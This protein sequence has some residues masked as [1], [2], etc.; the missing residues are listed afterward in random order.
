MYSHC[1][2]SFAG[3]RNSAA[4]LGRRQT[5]GQ[6][7]YSCNLVIYCFGY[8]NDCWRVRKQSGRNRHGVA[9]TTGRER[10]DS[11][12]VEV[13]ATKCNLTLDNQEV[14][15]PGSVLQRSWWREE[16][17]Y[18]GET[19][20]CLWGLGPLSSK[21]YSLIHIYRKPPAVPVNYSNCM[22]LLFFRSLSWSFYTCFLT[23]SFICWWLQVVDHG[24]PIS[25][26]DS[27]REASSAFFKSSLEDKNLCANGKEGRVAGYG[28]VFKGTATSRWDWVDV[29]T[30]RVG[31]LPLTDQDSSAWP[32]KPAS[33]K[34]AYIHTSLHELIKQ[35]DFR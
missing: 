10:I 29:L 7:A 30:H 11:G 25:V 20:T 2:Q 6:L 27:M 3:F 32:S 17:R 1:V 28:R 5:P 12:S 4:L 21:Y 35:K 19:E 24:I 34:W 33:Y 15:S 8:S 23:L 18:N 14:H 26:I 16:S 22:M 13:S 9:A 31:P